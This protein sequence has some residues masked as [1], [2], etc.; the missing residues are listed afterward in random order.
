MNVNN[1][2]RFVKTLQKNR[3]E[4]EQINKEKRQSEKKTHM[5]ILAVN[6]YVHRKFCNNWEVNKILD[7]DGNMS[8][9]EESLEDQKTEVWCY[10]QIIHIALFEKFF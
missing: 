9:T 2:Y 7:R 3:N 1:S 5:N 4:I 8:S 10:R 6:A